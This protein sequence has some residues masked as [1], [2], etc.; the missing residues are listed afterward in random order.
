MG[1]FATI[2]PFGE[3]IEIDSI[4][5]VYT[6]QWHSDSTILY[7]KTSDIGSARELCFYDIRNRMNS[8][9]YTEYN[10]EFDVEITK[11]DELLFCTIQSKTENEVYLIKPNLPFPEMELIKKREKGV[12][13]KVKIKNGIYL[14]V[15]DEKVGSSIEFHTF[16]DPGN[17]S[18]FTSSYKDDYIVDILTMKDKTIALVYDK[19]MPKL[20]FIGHNDDKWQELELKLG[21]GDY[22]LIS[23][24]DT[25]NSFLFSFSSP[26]QPYSKYKYNFNTS[27]LNVVSKTESVNPIYYK[28]ISTKRIWAKSHDGVKIPITIVKNRAAT[29][30][31]SGLI[32]KV[33]GAYGAITTPSFDAQDA[34]LLEQGYTIAYAHVRGE[35]ILG[36]SWYKSGRELQ[37]EKSI[38]DYVACA[39]YLIKKEYTTSEL[40]IGYGNSAGGL[41]V[42][43]ATNLKPELFNTIILDHPYLDVINT[44]MN[45]T[46]PLTIDEYKEWGNPKN[47][48]VYDYILKY[49]SYQ[50]IIPQQYP[51]VLLITSYQDYQT[52]IWQVAKYTARLRENNLSDSE[53]IML[54]DMN[55]GHIGNTTGKEWIKLFAETYSFAKEK[56]KNPVPNKTYK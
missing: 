25:T 13:A 22:H 26:S 19:S 45:D 36:Q 24:D 49:S 6:V 53:I 11:I 55:S 41:I 37:K 54:T 8:T 12:I 52:P 42:A 4:S 29:K 30:S 33:Y 15:N 2:L 43:Q 27:K 35:S 28:Y 46:L 34:I 44:M 1:D 47:K 56:N 18:L 40:L 50:N 5:N 9:I 31:N 17:Q 38:L 21:I 39:E 51:N 3:D 20:K 7:T 48:E 10:P 32:L 23:T 16:S 14:L